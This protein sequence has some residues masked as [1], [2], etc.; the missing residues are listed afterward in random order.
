MKTS[1]LLALLST[2]GLLIIAADAGA[3]TKWKDRMGSNSL[4][5]EP[6]S[7]NAPSIVQVPPSGAPGIATSTVD[8]SGNGM[9]RRDHF[10]IYSDE[11][12]PSSRHH[13]ANRHMRND[14]WT[15]DTTENFDEVSTNS[16]APDESNMRARH[17]FRHDDHYFAYYGEDIPSLRGLQL[18]TALNR[19]HHI[20]MKE[21]DMA[22][23]A[24]SHAK[25][26]DVLNLA[27]QIRADHEAL[28]NKVTALAKRRNISLNSFQLATF[29]K[30]VRDRLS[31]LNGTEFEQAFLRVNE[32][33]HEEAARSLRMVRNDLSDTETRNLINEAL[34]RMTAHMNI[35][36]TENRAKARVEEGD[37][38]E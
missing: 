1:Q 34:P 21:I 38:G 4:S 20:N 31:K 6:R 12:A 14:A 27:H 19:L 7:D 30:A 22:K 8:P 23:L 25:S 5:N 10:D 24:E 16:A 2:L 15:N 11:S 35:P 3:N 36:S 32:R 37:I 33:G 13:A 28:E 17:E 18:E 26:A 9:A 29:E